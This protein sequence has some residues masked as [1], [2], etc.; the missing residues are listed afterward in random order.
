MELYFNE[1]HVKFLNVKESV[2]TLLVASENTLYGTATSLKNLA[3][4]ATMPGIIAI[5]ASL[6][7]TL[8][9]SYFV[10]LYFISPINKINKAVRNFKKTGGAINIKVNSN[11][12][13]G[14][15]ADSVNYLSNK[16]NE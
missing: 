9:F 16:L 15:L 2:E 7:F 12:E 8:L 11:D 10:F 5:L 3:N 13:I 14:E 6:V 1:A 4:R